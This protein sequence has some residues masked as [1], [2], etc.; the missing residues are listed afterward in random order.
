MNREETNDD[1]GAILA[2]R[3]EDCPVIPLRKAVVLALDDQ[4]L[5]VRLQFVRNMIAASGGTED[6]IP[7]DQNLAVAAE[8][9][10]AA[11]EILQTYPKVAMACCEAEPAPVRPRRKKKKPNPPVAKKH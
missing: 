5:L 9:L 7:C 6:S 10:M 3:P 11:I 4:P 8:V 1:E 2:T